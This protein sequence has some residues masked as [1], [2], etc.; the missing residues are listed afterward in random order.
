MAEYY[1]LAQLPSLDGI[2]ENML[3]PITQERFLELCNQ[4]LSK[5][6]QIEIQKLTLVPPKEDEKSASVLIQ[7]WN[8]GERNLRLALA[9]ARAEKMK[10]SF[11][12]EKTSLPTELIRVANTAVEIQSPMEAEKFLDNHRLAFLET[13]RPMDAFSEDAVYYYGLKLKLIL[14][15]RQFNTE[16]G[17]HAY[18]NIYNSILYGDRL[19]A[20]Q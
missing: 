9:W 4:F 3:P 8:A 15:M 12:T 18:K 16:I 6:A 1:L 2:G 7:A 20:V 11:D 17:A 10:K 5:K 13:L 19:E 14:R